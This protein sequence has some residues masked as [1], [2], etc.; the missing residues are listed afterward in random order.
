[1][2]H[3]IAAVGQPGEQHGGEAMM[4]TLLKEGGAKA[5]SCLNTS[6]PASFSSVCSCCLTTKLITKLAS[7]SK[8]P[9]LHKDAGPMQ[10][11]L[12][13]MMTPPNQI[14]HLTA[15]DCTAWQH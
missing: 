2:Q 15:T 14:D 13:A 4:N 9:D 10:P 6:V 12:P 5:M 8:F 3:V 7:V 11:C 1:M